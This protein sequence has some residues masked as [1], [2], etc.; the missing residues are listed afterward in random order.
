M[1]LTLG[2]GLTLRDTFRRLGEKGSPRLRPIAQ[3]IG[4]RL[5]H[6]NSLGDALEP[7]AHYFPPLF[8]S[9]I[10]VG[11]ETGQLPEICHELED[12]F[13]LQQK[14]RRKIISGSIMPILQFLAALGVISLL[15]IVLDLIAQSNGGRG[16]AVLGFRGVG[17]AIQFLALNFCIF[18]TVF[19][20]YKVFTGGLGRQAAFDYLLWR[21]PILGPCVR[22]LVM[23]RFAL[24][25]QL[26]LDTSIP[27]AKAL[28]L[29]LQ[30][31]G[32][33]AFAQQG[34]EIEMAV[35][36]GK[37]LTDALGR[38]RLMPVDFLAMVAVG[39][40]GGRLVEIMHHQAE[41]YQEEAGMR[42]QTVTRTVTGAVWLI[43]AFFMIGAIFS[44]AR[45]Y[46][47]ALGV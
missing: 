36:Q 42:M 5:G 24:A 6:G 9:M 41:Q 3:R 2:A 44:I 25:M 18:V 20:A 14:H 21:V 16:P 37:D 4:E 26:T 30:A 34:D 7:E 19:V 43:Y 38:G 10:G 47:S 12:Y 28:R 15:I 23:T 39:E 27:V 45:I 8:T 22:A 31:T 46:L 17:G 29:S 40:E 32:N 11:E 13:R 33:E 1:R 35:T